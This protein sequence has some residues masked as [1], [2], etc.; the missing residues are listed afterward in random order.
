MF[1]III[2]IAIIAGAIWVLREITAGVGAADNRWPP[3]AKPLLSENEQILYQRLKALYPDLVV[4]VQVALSQL[5]VVKP[6]TPNRLAIR[7]RFNQLVADFVLCRPDFTVVAIIELDDSSHAA[8]DRQEADQRKTKAVESAGLR[9]IRIPA[10]PVPSEDMLRQLLQEESPPPTPVVAAHGVV[11]PVISAE[12]AATLVPILGLVLFGLVVVGG[13][14]AYSHVV[15]TLPKM[16]S[17]LP[18]AVTPAPA[19][20]PAPVAPVPVDAAAVQQAEHKRL[21]AERASTVRK[22][23]DVL[24]KRKQAAWAQYYKAPASCEHP[25]AWTDQVECGNQ[26]I[27]AKREFE[28]LWQRQMN[29]QPPSTNSD[30]SVVIGRPQATSPPAVS[31]GAAR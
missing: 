18:V 7:N 12:A 26:Y 27:R 1:L 2:L 13:W 15:R 6:A 4:L 16:M 10:G 29:S 8:P 21:E 9:L 19:P 14:M 11:P 3:F 20:R 28:K 25:P 30:S 17:P 24:A 22:A 31:T 23:A 5:L